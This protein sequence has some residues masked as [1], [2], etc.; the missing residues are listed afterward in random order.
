MKGNCIV[1]SLFVF[2]LGL[3]VFLVGSFFK[4]WLFGF[5]FGNMRD[6]SA[7][8]KKTEDQ[9]GRQRDGKIQIAGQQHIATEG[10]T[11]TTTEEAIM[12]A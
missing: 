10:Q 3:F 8:D 2:C 6:V 11:E 4:C 7:T 9:T 12:A 5:D 1:Y